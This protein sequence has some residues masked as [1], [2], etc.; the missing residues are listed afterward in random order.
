M[1]VDNEIEEFEDNH[2]FL[3]PN[4]ATLS[5]DRIESDDDNHFLNLIE[6][7]I[8]ESAFVDDE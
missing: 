2:L 1:F 8:N 3:D 4:D 5:G 7:A 6:G